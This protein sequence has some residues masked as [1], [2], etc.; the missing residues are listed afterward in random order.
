M[1]KH[2][3]HI[4]FFILTSIMV[5]CSQEKKTDWRV[6]FDK[7]SKEPYGCYIAYHFLHDYFPDNTIE[8][9][10]NPFTEINRSLLN[11]RAA[12]NKQHLSFV[13]CRSFQTDSL[14]LDKII[15]YVRQGN[16]L[17]IMAENFSENMFRYFHL[18]YDHITPSGNNYFSNSSNMLNNQHVTLFYNHRQYRFTYDGLPIEYAFT[19]DSSYKAAYY[20]MGYVNIVDTPNRLIE[21]EGNG[22][23]MI[24]RNP[25]SMTNHFLLQHDNINY[26]NYFF[27]YFNANPKTVTWYTMYERKIKDDSENDLSWLLNFP[28]LFYTFLLIAVLLLFYT[29]FESKRRQRAIAILPGNKNTSLEFIET[30]GL[31]YYN[32]KDHKNLSEKMIM[33]Y[34]ETIRSRYGLK[35]NEL[36]EEFASLLSQK[37]HHSLTDTTAFIAYIRYIRDSEKITDTDIRHLYHQLKIFL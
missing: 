12:R 31:L 29:L 25:V 24:C 1:R 2:F 30:V 19:K 8:S 37:T 4:L 27:S 5:S 35:T 28:P 13:V 10:R 16:S 11:K 21:F 18:T 17:C 20:Y 14:E 32:K 6:T 15:R 23:L 9:G 34:L 36:N 22:S 3:S 33:H 7:N 26:L